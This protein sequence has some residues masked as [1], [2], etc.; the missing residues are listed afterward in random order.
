MQEW[1]EHGDLNKGFAA[2]TRTIDA[3]Y[4]TDYVYH[5]QMEPLNGVASYDKRTGQLEVWAGTQAPSHCLR[6]VAAVTGVKEDNVKINRMYSGGAFG[7]RGAVD[8]DYVVDAALLARRT[9][10][11]VKLVWSREDDVRLARLKPMTAQYLRAG[12]DRDGA[13]IAW[14]H[15]V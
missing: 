13:L 10:K 6:S 15:R 9:G 4:L 8:H 7:R 14:H 5:A 11:P 3:L 2:S 12:F 1:E